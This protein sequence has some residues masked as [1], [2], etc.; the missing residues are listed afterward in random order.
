MKRLTLDEL[1]TVAVH[2]TREALQ[3]YVR[4]ISPY[5]DDPH[6]A[7]TASMGRDVVEFNLIVN[8]ERQADIIHLMSTRVSR[9][10]GE[11][12]G[13]DVHLPPDEIT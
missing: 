2:A 3:R 5:K 12:L 4:A 9:T 13:I 11:V 8:S 1:E 7:L 10:T 6:L